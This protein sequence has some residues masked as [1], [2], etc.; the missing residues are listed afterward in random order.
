MVNQFQVDC[1][2]PMS[3]FRQ[4]PSGQQMDT[5]QALQART[6]QQCGYGTFC[7]IVYPEGKKSRV[8]LI[9]AI[10]FSAILLLM[11]LFVLFHICK[12]NNP[13]FKLAEKE[14]VELKDQ[15]DVNTE[16]TQ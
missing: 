6:V 3:S 16:R 2:N 15:S 7:E 1:K 11:L 10:I 8:G 9:V 4:S 14:S 12:N 5:S 13:Y